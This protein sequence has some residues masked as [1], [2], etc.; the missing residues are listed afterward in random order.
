M[1]TEYATK[2]EAM[3]GIANRITDGYRK[4]RPDDYAKYQVAIDQAV[5]ATQNAYGQNIFPAMKATWAAYPVNIGHFTSPGCM[6]CHD[7][8][9]TDIPPSNN[10]NT[11]TQIISFDAERIKAETL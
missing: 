7:G 4:D 2:E 6:R 11:P 9:H 10:I 1:A 8:N 5:V 3:R